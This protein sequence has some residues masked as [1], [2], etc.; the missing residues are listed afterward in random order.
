VATPREGLNIEGA[1]ANVLDVL[2]DDE[3]WVP[4]PM[5]VTG[6]LDQA[7]VRPDAKELMAQA[8]R[9]ATREVKEKATEAVGEAL[10]GLFGGRRKKN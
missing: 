3:G 6:T 9:G 1:S 5:T 8:R 2:A 7:K 10:G 4:V